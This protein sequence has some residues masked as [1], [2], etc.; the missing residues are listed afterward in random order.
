[1]KYKSQFVSYLILLI[2][3]ISIAVTWNTSGESAETVSEIILYGN[4]KC[5]YC[6]DT[7]RWLK[8]N[9][10]PYIYRDVELYGTFQEEMYKK[11]SG[12]GIARFPVLDVKGQILIRPSTGDI[13]KALRG[14]KVMHNEERK[15][16]SPLWRP[17]KQKSIKLSF[18]SVRPKLAPSDLIL[19][20]DGSADG[21]KLAAALKK[22]DIPFTLKELNLMGNAAFFDLSSRLA[23]N[24]Y[25]NTLY[26][27]VAEVRGE[28]IMKASLDD[29]KTLII[30]VTAE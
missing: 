28:F 3:F 16:R 12:A 14:E 9:N 17:E 24:G 30:E 11:L 23:D 13:Q 5:G 29:I 7:R 8:E 2:L 21:N 27:P 19:F 26:F 22:E 20:T 1:M 10:I 18:E 15:L 6:R 25:G 4:E